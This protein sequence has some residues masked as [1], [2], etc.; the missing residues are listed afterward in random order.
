M[1]E[2]AGRGGAR[3]H[4]RELGRGV[5]SR[6]QAPLQPGGLGAG[7]PAGAAEFVF[8]FDDVEGAAGDVRRIRVGIRVWIRGSAGFDVFCPF[9]VEVDEEVGVEFFRFGRVGGDVNAAFH[10]AVEPGFLFEF[11]FGPLEGG[12]VDC[13]GEGGRVFLGH[14]AVIL[15]DVG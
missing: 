15:G 12:G 3:G 1:D 4:L 8:V 7:T 14:R 2:R 5:R 13:V 11:A 6:G 9:P 10:V